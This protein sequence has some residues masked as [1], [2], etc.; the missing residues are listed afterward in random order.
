MT[1]HQKNYVVLPQN[2]SHKIITCSICKTVCYGIATLFVLA[3]A[4]K[5]TYLDQFQA[6]LNDFSI[7]S[8]FPAL[9]AWLIPSV[10]I[11]I[12]MLLLFRKTR[13]SG[14]YA[15]LTWFVLFTLYLSLVLNAHMPM[16]CACDGLWLSV[17]WHTQLLFNSACI[18]VAISAL[19]LHTKM[20]RGLL[21]YKTYG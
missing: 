19:L 13:L 3:A 10:E 20:R 18:F 14:L 8:A 9:L 6:K 21:R 1:K 4:S 17:G 16:P 11:G 5:I 2:Y 15:S 12:G 7:L